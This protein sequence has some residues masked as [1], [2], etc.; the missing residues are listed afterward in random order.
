MR[1]DDNGRFQGLHL[2]EQ[3]RIVVS[4]PHLDAWPVEL[5]PDQTNVEIRLPQ[6]AA[7]V[8]NYDIPG[9]AEK[10]HVYYQRLSSHGAESERPIWKGIGIEPDVT[11]KNGQ[12]TTLRSMTPGYYQIFR[13]KLVS[14][15]SV[16]HYIMMEREFFEIKPGETHTINWNRP[17]GGARV[18]A[19]VKWPKEVALQGMMFSV[20]GQP[21]KDFGNLDVRN[22]LDGGAVDLETG[23]FRSALIPPGTYTLDIATQKPISKERL[24]FSSPIF[25]EYRKSIEVVIPEGVDEVTLDEIILDGLK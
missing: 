20:V 6:P 7:V 18:T 19:T 25:P 22:I 24:A 21:K 9:A 14:M 13:Q 8:I 10:T 4:S 11:I 16:G 1:T 17:V 12:V 15:E 23:Q 3:N 5:T 2:N